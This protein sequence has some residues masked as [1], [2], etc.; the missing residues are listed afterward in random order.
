[1]ISRPALLILK[2]RLSKGTL[3]QSYGLMSHRLRMASLR[4]KMPNLD[5]SY[6]PDTNL[7]YNS[8]II[9]IEA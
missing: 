4:E 9:R 8:L 5:M 2:L 6:G 1:M 3:K 7:A